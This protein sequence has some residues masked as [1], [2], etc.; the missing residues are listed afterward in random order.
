M[1]KPTVKTRIQLKNDT[2]E[3]WSRAVNFIPL[4]GEV[5]LYSSDDSHPFFRIKVGD[6][7]NTVPDLP[8]IDAATIDGVDVN[9]IVAKKL[10]H[11]ISFGANQEFVFDGSQDVVIPVYTGNII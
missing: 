10:N 3:N 11:S 6:G 1:A 8:F 9:N 2:E 5:I 4:L 7:I